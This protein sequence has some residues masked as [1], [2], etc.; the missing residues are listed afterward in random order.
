M[1]EEEE[2]VDDEVEDEEP[3]RPAP[4]SAPKTSSGLLGSAWALQN[5][6]ERRWAS[7]SK[8][9]FARVLKMARKPEPEEF[10]Q[11]AMVVLVG[12]G[13]IGMIGFMTYL[14]VRWLLTSVLHV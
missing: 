14:F 1:V 2:M 13:I 10:R 5:G 6:I 4:R 7:L 9:R 11:S 12:I 3:V 8:G